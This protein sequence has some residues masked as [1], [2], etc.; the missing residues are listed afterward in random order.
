MK[1]STK[2][3]KRITQ[4]AYLNILKTIY[5]IGLAMLIPFIYIISFSSLGL[6]FVK[7]N[8][9]MFLT[10]MSL[11]ALSSIGFYNLA[12]NNKSRTYIMMGIITLVP[13]L[14]AIFFSFVSE[15]VVMG[16]IAKYVPGFVE[17]MIEEYIALIVP[18]LTA[19]TGLY[20]LIGLTLI[21]IGAYKF[22]KI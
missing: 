14:I 8:I 1:L 12:G 9:I 22:K 4:L 13:A 16:F 2:A 3:K 10:A 7:V 18:R 15:K 20:V 21:V 17:Q 19:L 11:I 5:F 6:H